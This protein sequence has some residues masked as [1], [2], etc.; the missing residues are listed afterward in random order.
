MAR[1]LGDPVRGSFMSARYLIRFDDICSTMNWPMW[2]RVE[3][4]LMEREIRPIVAVVPDNRDPNLD[5]GSPRDDFWDRVRDWQRRGWSI[6]WHG[7]QHVY[8]SADA[9][10]VGINRRS[11]FA[12]IPRGEQHRK[13]GSAHEIFSR[14]RVVPDLWVAPGHSFDRNTIELLRSFGVDVISDGF[15]ARPVL[16]LGALWI[17]QQLWNLRRM[18]YGLWTVCHH[19]NRWSDEDLLRFERGIARF[20][21]RIVCLADVLKEPRRPRTVFD[22]AFATSYRGAVLMKRALSR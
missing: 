21:A 1:Q 4:L 20:K 13:L 6:G 9:G 3:T 15:Y 7:F 17:P 5:S 10:L 12:G 22:A 2:G 18:P 11:E 8:E 14:H 16:T 19:V